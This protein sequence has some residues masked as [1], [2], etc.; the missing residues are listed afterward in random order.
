L[1]FLKNFFLGLVL[2][3]TM[4]FEISSKE[5]SALELS[6][7]TPFIGELLNQLRWCL[8][9]I[10]FK[11]YFEL[12]LNLLLLSICQRFIQTHSSFFGEIILDYRR[13]RWWCL[14]FRWLSFFNLGLYLLLLLI[15]HSILN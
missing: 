7:I 14:N 12:F 15:I 4:F 3:I 5:A 8:L 13:R 11:L 10:L 9:T 6:V 1:L 2:Q